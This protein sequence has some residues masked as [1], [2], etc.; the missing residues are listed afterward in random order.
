MARSKWLTG[1]PR[2]NLRLVSVYHL[3]KRKL[4]LEDVE[5]DQS[6]LECRDNDG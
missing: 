1:T 6:R 4:H 5:L 3:R 2:L